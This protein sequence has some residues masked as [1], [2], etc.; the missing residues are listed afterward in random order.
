MKPRSGNSTQRPL[1]ADVS[2]TRC[3]DVTPLPCD[4]IALLRR[5][6]TCAM[7]AEAEG[8]SCPAGEAGRRDCPPRTCS[9]PS[10]SHINYV[11]CWEGS[12]SRF[13]CLVSFKPR[14]GGGSWETGESMAT[15]FRGHTG[16]HWGPGTRLLS[17]ALLPSAHP[18][19]CHDLPALAAPSPPPPPFFNLNQTVS[20]ESDSLGPGR[21]TRA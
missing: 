1:L 21:L 13:L 15:G 9:V 11:L 18:P 19:T 7:R 3:T 17:V 20:S 2:H 14:G 4:A 6:Q 10:V 5:V 12:A 16:A 8:G